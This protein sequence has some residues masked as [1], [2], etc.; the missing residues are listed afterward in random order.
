MVS[1]RVIERIVTR[2]MSS[3]TTVLGKCATFIF[4]QFGCTKNKYYN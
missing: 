4:F 1:A 3:T 2:R